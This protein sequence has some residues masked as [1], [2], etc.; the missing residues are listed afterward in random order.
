MRMRHRGAWVGRLQRR[1][2]AATTM[3]CGQSCRCAAQP[4][5]RSAAVARMPPPRFARSSKPQIRSP[6]PETG[7]HGALIIGWNAP[8]GFVS[9]PCCRGT[10]RLDVSPG[11][12]ACDPPCRAVLLRGTCAPPRDA[13]SSSGRPASTRSRCL[14]DSGAS[15]CRAGI[16]LHPDCDDVPCAAPSSESPPADRRLRCR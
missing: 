2:H 12:T 14:P 5:G 4:T 16:R 3:V 15:G 10:S 6:Q 8:G 9:P 11:G 1:A 7:R 13:P